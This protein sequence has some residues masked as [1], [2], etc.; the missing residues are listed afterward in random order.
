MLDVLRAL[1]KLDATPAPWAPET[2]DEGDWEHGPQIYMR[3]VV[4]PEVQ[5]RPYVVSFDDDT[6]TNQWADAELI[7]GLRNLAPILAPI[8]ER[9]ELIEKAALELLADLKAEYGWDDG[10]PLEVALKPLP[11]RPA[12]LDAL[13]EHVGDALGP[14]SLDEILLFLRD[15]GRRDYGGLVLGGRDA[16]LVTGEMERGRRAALAA[17][18]VIEMVDHGNRGMD[19]R[20]REILAAALATPEG[21]LAAEEVRF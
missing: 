18:Q 6:G 8:L 17:Q 19:V 14:V 15:A 2:L 5:G 1:L 9:Y 4:A 7:A 11:E 21:S 12:G 10:T 20:Y 16:T 13:M 3:G